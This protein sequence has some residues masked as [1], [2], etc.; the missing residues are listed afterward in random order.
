MCDLRVIIERFI[1]LKTK[2]HKTYNNDVRYTER[3]KLFNFYVIFFSNLYYFNLIYFYL[4]F[5]FA[6]GTFTQI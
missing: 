1:K 3:I 6:I 2:L 4:F 5:F